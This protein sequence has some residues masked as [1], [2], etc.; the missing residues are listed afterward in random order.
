MAIDAGGNLFVADTNNHTIRKITPA[1]VVTTVAGTAGVPGNS[2]GTG[3]AALFFYPYGVAVDGSGNLYVTDHNNA[4]RKGVPAI[5]DLATIDAAAGQPGVMRLLGTAPQTATSWLWALIRR[6]SGSTAQLSSTSVASPTFTPD[7]AGLFI[8]QLTA[9]NSAGAR[10]STV[11]LSAGAFPKGDANGDGSV[12]V[13]DIFYLI[14]YLFTAGPAPINGNA[15]GD[16][17]VTV[18]DVF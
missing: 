4:I 17:S 8:F 13:A 9:S 11:S 7:I 2:D 14:S 6:P 1:G 12:T 16:T 15:N 3:A 5:G 10:I 18:A